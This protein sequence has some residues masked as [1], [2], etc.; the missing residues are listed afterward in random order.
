MTSDD[1]E[2]ERSNNNSNEDL[3]DEKAEELTGTAGQA[4]KDMQSMS[5][6]GL[7]PALLAGLDLGDSDTLGKAL[8]FVGAELTKIRNI[9]A[10]REKEQAKVQINQD[11]VNLIVKEFEVSKASAE[12]SLREN[13]GNLE[14][15]LRALIA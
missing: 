4:S 8:Q 5:G 12:K 3:D 9:K 6:G 11:D 14:Q 1:K 2:N 13:S 7:D 10:A 15:T